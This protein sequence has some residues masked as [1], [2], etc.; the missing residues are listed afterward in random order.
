MAGRIRS[1]KPEILMAV[2]IPPAD[3][4]YKSTK[5][6]VYF[7]QTSISG[8]VKIGCAWNVAYRL[9]S[10]RVGN[11]EALE[12]VGW[13]VGNRHLER[14]I[15][16]QFEADRIRAEWF[17]PSDELINFIKGLPQARKATPQ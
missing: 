13:I 14:A 4:S 6:Y 11:H 5:A 17:R 8:C 1:I 12:L 2:D 10:L 16:K 3:F 15:Q 7:I 9:S